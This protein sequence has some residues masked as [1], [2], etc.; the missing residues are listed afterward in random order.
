MY[1]EKK[2]Q[3]QEIKYLRFS[4]SDYIIMSSHLIDTAGNEYTHS[5]LL[6]AYSLVTFDL[7][8]NIYNR[9]YII[10]K[11]FFLIDF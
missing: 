11:E 8:S 3:F 6:N 9:S 4:S 7:I 2:R 1:K 10:C 5:I